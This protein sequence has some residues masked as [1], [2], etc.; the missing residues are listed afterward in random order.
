MDEKLKIS[1]VIPVYNAERY[2][3]AV[4]SEE[5]IGTK[6]DGTLIYNYAPD[7]RSQGKTLEIKEKDLAGYSFYGD[8]KVPGLFV[9]GHVMAAQFH[10]EKSGSVGLNILR[11][12]CEGERV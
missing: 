12:F 11:A 6:R 2:I 4:K 8:V 3:F 7:R 9:R 10:P 5:P 1:V